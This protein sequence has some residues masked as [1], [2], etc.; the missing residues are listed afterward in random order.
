MNCSDSN[1]FAASIEEIEASGAGKTYAL[2]HKALWV[3]DAFPR[4][5][6]VIFRRVAKELRQTT[7]AT[8]FKICPPDFYTHGGRRN[9]QDGHG[10]EADRG[11]DRHHGLGI[12]IHTEDVDGNREEQ[13][14]H[15]GGCCV[16]GTAER[17]PAR[18]EEGGQEGHG[19]ER[20]DPATDRAE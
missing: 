16:V 11:D 3:S 13:E 17:L 7:M 14:P 1:E 8:F 10:A 20:D 12:G 19:D 5:R 2:C 18:C 6:G 15:Q 4:N 9:D